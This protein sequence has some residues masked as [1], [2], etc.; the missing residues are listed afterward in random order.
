MP[1]SYASDRRVEIRKIKAVWNRSRSGWINPGRSFELVQRAQDTTIHLV[2]EVGY[3]LRLSRVFSL[4][5]GAQVHRILV[6]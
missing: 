4:R 6:H 5:I 3:S 1:S 2:P